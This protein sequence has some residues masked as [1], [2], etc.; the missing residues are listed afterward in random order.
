[1]KNSRSVH[2]DFGQ[3]HIDVNQNETDETENQN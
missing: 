3:Y 1:M 2:V